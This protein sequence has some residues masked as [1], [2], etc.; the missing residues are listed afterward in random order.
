MTRD[1]KIEIVRQ[2]VSKKRQEKLKELEAVK[3]IVDSG[4]DVK[5]RLVSSSETGNWGDGN[6]AVLG[7]RAGFNCEYCGKYLLQSVDNYVDWEAD[8]IDPRS[9]GGPNNFDNLAL[10]CRQCNV[11]FKSNVTI[12]RMRELLNM[13]EHSIRVG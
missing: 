12:A 5:N 11:R 7:L 9:A 4:D 6:A 8:H 2:Y 13:L 1:E 3:E 10:S